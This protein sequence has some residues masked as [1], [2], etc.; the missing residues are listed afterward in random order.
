VGNLAADTAVTGGDG[1]Y[2][3]QLSEDW[4]IWGPNGGYIASVALRAAGVHSRFDRPATIVG[5]FLGVAA[6][7]EVDI[8]VTTLRTAKRAESLHVS[9]TQRGEP[10]FD[11]L[12]WAVGDVDGLTHDVTTMPDVADPGTLQSTAEL[13]KDSPGPRYD[14]WRNF[15]ERPTFW[16]KS[17]EEWRNRQP[18]PPEYGCWY[19]YVPQATFDDPWVDACRS[20]I[21]LDT[22]AWPAACNLHIQN[23]YMAPSIDISA[24]FHR[25]RPDE[26][27]LYALATS[28]SA[29]G[30]LVAGDGRVWARDGTLLA[31]GAS[32]LLCRP[33][34]TDMA[35]S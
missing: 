30:G 13:T 32:H 35:P 17:E 5:H 15:D 28:P 29:G 7:A 34:R 18:G 4:A 22:L 31:V 3:A 19:Q 27:W 1:S 16:H 10:V 14:F 33:F 26:P 11:A 12:V 23:Q 6:F 20:L 24:G 21:L 9:L 8:T 2:T 25:Y